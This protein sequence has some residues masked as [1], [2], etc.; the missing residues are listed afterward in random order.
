[1]WLLNNPGKVITVYDI[2]EILVEPIV[3]YALDSL[4]VDFRIYINLDLYR[5]YI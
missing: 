2:A 5:T 3:S 4:E 1:M